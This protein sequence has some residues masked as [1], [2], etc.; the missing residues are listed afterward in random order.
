M[1]IEH[2]FDFQAY[3]A[4]IKDIENI[5]ITEFGS[6]Y[7]HI[8]SDVNTKV[9]DIELHSENLEIVMSVCGSKKDSRSE[10]ANNFYKKL[11]ENQYKFQPDFNVYIR[12]RKERLGYKSEVEETKF[13]N[14]ILKNFEGD[15]IYSV[16]HGMPRLWRRQGILY[17]STRDKIWWG[18]CD[19]D[20]ATLFEMPYEIEEMPFAFE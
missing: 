14:C 13:I 16:E 8:T 20:R 12:Y 7:F 1:A 4:N 17:L 9:T 11:Y 19:F 5:I 3:R 15:A 2:F 18:S 10:W 6:D